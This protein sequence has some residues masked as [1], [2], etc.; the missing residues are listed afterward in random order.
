M[1]GGGGVAAGGATTTT[2]SH[3]GGGGDWWSAAVSS[4]SAP[5][6]ETMQGFGGWSAAVVAVDGGGNTSRSAA[7]NTASSESPGSL[8]TGSSI[9]FQ[10]PAGG[11]A[12]PAAI[13]VHAQTVAGGGGGGGWNQQPFLD[14]SGFHGYM[15]SSRNDHHT[16][17]HHHQ[18]NTPSLMSNSSS[19]NGVMLQE[20]Q[21]DQNYQFLSNLGFELLSSPTSPYGGGGGFRSSLLR[22]LTEPA[23]AAKPNDS[24]GFQQYHHHQPAMNLQPPAAAAG[25]EP[26]QFTN[27]TAAPFW[28]PSSG[29]TVAAE[30]TA[31]GG[32][33]A[34]P[35]QPTPASLAA[36]RA[37]EGVGD[38]S[39]IITKKAKADSTPLKKS[40][41]GTP[42]ALPTTFKVRKE[43]LGDRVTALQQLVSPF[44]KTDTASVLHETIEYIKF[45]HDQVGAL[46]APY[47]KNRQQVPHLKNS[48]GV[49][50]DGGG[51][52][53]A[54]A[55]SK[56]DLTG[57]GLC[58]V[59]ISSTFAVASETP[60]DFWTPFGAAF[61]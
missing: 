56:R 16:N 9:T 23:A 3:G 17:H 2:G 43:K 38:S 27:S 50:N 14:G 44:G 5:A 52:G 19:N 37:L 15:S 39:S 54:T 18:I 21:H 47:L 22:S 45:L 32:A 13:A 36:K 55:A 41:T 28:N 25:R 61:R 59:P 42:S 34:S 58:L 24:P 46:S 10:E 30:G 57:R 20:H 53:E 11:V 48:T 12:D 49:D 4:C 26:L 51:G 31:L 29:F 35:A 6:P 60:V 1:Y 8:A 40:R 33:G 7:G